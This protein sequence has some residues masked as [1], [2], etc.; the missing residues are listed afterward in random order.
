MEDTLRQ[1]L[2]GLTRQATAMHD[3]SRVRLHALQMERQ[4]AV[5][6]LRAESKAQEAA[7]KE[8]A[9]TVQLRQAEADI[10]KVRGREA[11]TAAKQIADAA[12]AKRAEEQRL[13]AKEEAKK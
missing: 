8:L 3:E 12:K 11:A 10:A 9:L 6:T 13:R 5:E 1:R 7:E 4:Q 2:R